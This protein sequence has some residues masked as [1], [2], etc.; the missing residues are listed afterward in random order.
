MFF[1]GNVIW[2]C[3][4]ILCLPGQCLEPLPYA[5]LCFLRKD[6]VVMRFAVDHAQLSVAVSGRCCDGVFGRHDIISVAVNNF[7]ESTR[8]ARLMMN[9]RRVELGHIVDSASEMVDSLK[10]VA[11]ELKR[12]PSMLIRERRPEPLE[13]TR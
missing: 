12:N 6:V 10:E 1:D 9:E 3:R 8:Q 7:S 5:G 4:V 2:G 13:E 11:A